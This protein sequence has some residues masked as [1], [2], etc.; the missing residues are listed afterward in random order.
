MFG[1]DTIDMI[2]L[3]AG[4]TSTVVLIAA[5]QATLVRDPMRAR[6]KILND[7]RDALKAGVVTR[8]RRNS[9]IKKLD[10]VTILREWAGK[11]QLLQNEQTQKLS[12]MLMQAGYRSRD[13]LAVYQMAR[14]V[15][16]M[17]FGIVAVILFYGL[18]ALP[19][20]Q[21]MYPIMSVVM[22]F[23]GLKAPDAFVANVKAKRTDAIR[24]GLPDALDLLVVCA[25]AGLT[26]DAAMTRV[27][28]ELGRA[29]PELSEEFSLTAIELGFLPDRREAMV[30]LS[31]RVDL[32]DLRGVVTTLI[33]AE[34]YGTP[35]ASSLRVLSSEFRGER[36]LRA[37]AKAAKLP[38]TLTVPLIV[39]IL[40]TLFVVLMGP[41]AC[42]VMDDLSGNSR[43]G[44]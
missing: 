31:N 25:E 19:S 41:A 1:L 15:L 40:P 13:A 33:Q 44:N 12:D 5:Y 22:V 29:S 37:E 42:Q 27:A 38:A 36:M 21:K 10:S 35:L 3:A 2:S 17:V 28:R 18:G 34:K 43:I 4:L 7:R 11:L 14:L 32:A 39:F 23:A 8:Q 26:L 30:N 16:P 6:M 20:M 9:P 24:K